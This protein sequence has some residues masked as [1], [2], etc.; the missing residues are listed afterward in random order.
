MA[1]VLVTGGTGLLGGHLVP[2][3]IERGHEVRVVARHLATV[4]D[5]AEL[6]LGDVRTGEGLGPAV[7]NVDAVV[8]A[9]TSPRRGARKTEVLGIRNTVDAIGKSVGHLIYVSIVGVDRNRLPY[10][11]AKWEAEQVVESCALPWTIQRATQFHDLID[12][13]LSYPLFISTPNLAFQV[14]DTAD[15]A[16][17]LADL[18]DTGPAGRAPDFG[19]PEVLSINDLAASRR[20][21][22]GRRAR[23]LRVPRIGPVRDFDNGVH[24]CPHQRSGQRTWREWLLTGAGPSALS[25]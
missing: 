23:L 4:A 17:R 25:R 3:L 24:L 10:Y 8:H 12:L 16:G 7:E 2:I 11:Q 6:L 15:F 13:F 19:G 5:G 21:I 18:V 22:T 1:R 14:V 20:E 9:A